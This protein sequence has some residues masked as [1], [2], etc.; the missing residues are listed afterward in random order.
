MHG[1]T[2]NQTTNFIHRR[3]NTQFPTTFYTV[4]NF[5]SKILLLNLKNKH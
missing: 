1:I 2:H 3:K 5:C 4:S